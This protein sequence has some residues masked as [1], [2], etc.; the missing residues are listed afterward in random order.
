MTQALEELAGRIRDHFA[1]RAATAEQR[2]FGGIAF[3]ERG[4]M[5][6]GVMKDGTLM[7]RVGKDGMA[8]ALTRPG[9]RAME[10]NGRKMGGFVVVD[11]DVIEDGDALADWLDTART[12]TATLPAK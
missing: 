1:P 10:M 6:A 2:M 5:V 3:M 4:N 8:D 11:G 12:F 7:V 9:C